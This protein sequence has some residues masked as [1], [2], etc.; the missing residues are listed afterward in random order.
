MNT[1]KTLSIIIPYIVLAVVFAALV[2]LAAYGFI[3]P[4]ESQTLAA[5]DQLSKGADIFAGDWGRAA[6][7]A[8]VLQPVYVLVTALCGG[9]DGIVY[10]MRVL[11]VAVDF[12]VALVAYRVLAGTLERAAS[13]FTALAYLVLVSC[14]VSLVG[15]YGIALTCAFAAGLFGRSAYL[16]ALEDDGTSLGYLRVLRPVLAG[17]FFI[18]AGLF[19]NSVGFACVFTLA[20]AA[21]FAAKSDAARFKTPLAW[22][23][24]GALLAA[25][26]YLLLALGYGD[27]GS[28]FC[29]L[30][31]SSDGRAHLNTGLVCEFGMIALLGSLAVS[32]A[33]GK[34]KVSRAVALMA[35]AFALVG[36]AILYVGTSIPALSAGSR[37]DA[38]P[39]K[40]LVC[41]PADVQAYEE[42]CE[43][44]R[45][46]DG[47]SIYVVGDKGNDWAYLL[48][49]GVCNDNEPAWVL[50]TGGTDDNPL[51]DALVLQNCGK[52]AG[53]ETCELYRRASTIG[54]ISQG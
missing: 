6:A 34:E 24:C 52:I 17:F 51:K 33:N 37:I 29:S 5:L 20:V 28:V 14:G 47:G 11:F 19:S 50:K 7:F 15:P 26:C 49:D 35:L 31:S 38:G 21:I 1:N 10:T 48:F 36:A 54:S 32:V 40:E 46:A 12:V 4:L 16:A 3:S 2:Q 39:A 23:L 27:P 9:A 41:A 8:P 25:A 18:C 13:L 53:N 44:A 43:L 42:A 45:K 22:V 30:L